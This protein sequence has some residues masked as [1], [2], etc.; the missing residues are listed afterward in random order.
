M[1]CAGARDALEA[2]FDGVD[3]GARL[4]HAEDHADA[5]RP[6]AAY[7]REL[8][9][10]AALVED[11]RHDPTPIEVPPGLE[12]RL[13]HAVERAKP[14]PRRALALASLLTVVGLVLVAGAS[15]R[16]DRSRT[17]ALRLTAQQAHAEAISRQVDRDRAAAL[18][19]PMGG[20][21]TIAFAGYAR[22]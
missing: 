22:R 4:A 17:E 21:P 16:A 9:A 1:D 14:R 15:L 3:L 18:A 20:A 19:D 10:Y 8:R 6:C 2:A 13:L 7:R 5:C 11:A 12:D